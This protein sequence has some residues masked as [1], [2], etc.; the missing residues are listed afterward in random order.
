MAEVRVQVY[1]DWQCLR[2]G[3]MMYN[4]KSML[5]E[6]RAFH[7]YQYFGLDGMMRERTCAARSSEGVWLD[8]IDAVLIHE[9][10][11][12]SPA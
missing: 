1:A 8:R 9:V 2:C 4:P 3:R 10:S 7:T 5:G 12:P 11:V 6:D